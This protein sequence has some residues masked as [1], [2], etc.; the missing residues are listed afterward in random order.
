MEERS[1]IQGSEFVVAPGAEKSS[2]GTIGV[3]VI[4]NELAG[5]RRPVFNS[6]DCAGV[7]LLVQHPLV[8]LDRDPVIVL[9]VALASKRFGPVTVAVPPA[10]RVA[11]FT[12]ALGGGRHGDFL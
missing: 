5:L 1:V 4:D 8:F 10:L 12:G 2:H 11:P 7:S 3:V 9:Q 6:A